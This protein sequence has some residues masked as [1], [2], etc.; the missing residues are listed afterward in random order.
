VDLDKGILKNLS[1]L[2][3]ANILTK[4]L[5]FL[6][7]IFSAN[8]LGVSDFGIYTFSISYLLMFSMILDLG[9]EQLLI[10]DIAKDKRNLNSY[11][12]NGICYKF[13][14]SLLLIL[15]LC[16]IL[17]FSSFSIRIKYSLFLMLFFVLTT[18][19]MTYL[20]AF[21]R[22]F[23][24]IKYESISII[25][26]K[27]S[28]ITFA[29]LGLLLSFGLFG[30]LTGLVLGNIVSLCYCAVV[31]FKKNDTLVF[32]P[33]VGEIRT[34]LKKA[35][36]FLVADVFIIIYFRLSSVMIM[37]ITG[38][39]TQVGLY[40]SSYRLIEMYLAL[41]TLLVTPVYPFLSRT[42]KENKQQ[43]IDVAGKILKVLLLVSIP[44]T[45]IVFVD[46]IRI[47]ELLFSSQFSAG[48]Y[49]L[50]IIILV[51][52]P[53]SIN[54]LLGTILAAIGKQKEAAVSVGISAFINLALNFILIHSF[55]Y[56]G[57]SF[58]IVISEWIITGLYLFFVIKYFGKLNI[59]SFMIKLLII[60]IITGLIVYLLN[61]Y[62]I[63]ILISISAG[64]LLYFA[65]LFLFRLMKISQFNEY[66]KILTEK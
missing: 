31:L 12:N 55:Q 24:K 53:L 54:V 57:A 2:V 5:W 45:V 6:F 63:Q 35:L 43:S 62:S 65:L 40:N 10:R 16:T 33:I 42:F 44:V 17:Y 64:V 18:S 32:N 28:A 14:A 66:Y 9:L 58:S 48:A 19:F 34:L 29:G 15:I 38:S 47:N 50:K 21:F 61:I 51:I 27:I 59:F 13:F 60:A 49:G 41:P 22:A 20:R 56:V 8:K 39:E 25:I 52:V 23:E 46:Y 30:F 1:W 37:F 7:V 3:I 36:P 26:E 11:F 4:P